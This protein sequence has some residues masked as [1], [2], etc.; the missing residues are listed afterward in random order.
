MSLRTPSALLIFSMLFLSACGNGKAGM[1]GKSG[2]NGNSAVNEDPVAKDKNH[3][4]RLQDTLPKQSGG[5][6]VI[7][8]NSSVITG[9]ILGKKAEG[10]NGFTL[11]VLV[12]DIEENEA[13]YES[14]IAKGGTYQ[15]VPGFVMEKGRIVKNPANQKLLKL[16]ELSP[17]STFRASVSLDQSNKWIIQEVLDTK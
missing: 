17:G 7:G 16:K 9:E 3:N 13:S 8:E 6:T 2:A 12:K 14:L 4:E 11:K 10:E 5:R 1:N 15:M